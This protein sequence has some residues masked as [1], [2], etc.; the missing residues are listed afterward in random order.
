MTDTEDTMTL[1]DLLVRAYAP[2]V[3]RFHLID[4]PAAPRGPAEPRAGRTRLRDPG[5]VPRPLA[6]RWRTA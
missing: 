6:S 1:M 3:A 2:L 4:G 5:I